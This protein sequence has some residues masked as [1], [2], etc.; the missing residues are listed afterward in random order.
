MRPVS[1]Q[2]A[3]KSLLLKCCNFAERS[4]TFVSKLAVNCGGNM[5]KRSRDYRVYAISI[6]NRPLMLPFKKET[7]L[8]AS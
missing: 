4:A 7:V 2:T 3:H 5:K 1:G 8:G 6:F